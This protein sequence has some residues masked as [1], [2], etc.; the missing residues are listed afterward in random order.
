MKTSP[1]PETPQEASSSEA[2][3]SA[4]SLP[5]LSRRLMQLA[6]QLDALQAEMDKIAAQV[7]DGGVQV[8]ALVSHLTDAQS[9]HLLQTRLA[10]FTE[11]M[12]SE[13]EQLNFLEM[14]LADLATQEQIV[15]L[16]ATVA[17]QGQ[18]SALAETLKNLVRGIEK[19]NRLGETKEQQLGSVLGTLQEI[20]ARRQQAAE[21]DQERQHEQTDA[22]RR[23]AR[24]ELAADLLPALDGLEVAL[25]R[26]RTILARQRHDLAALGQLPVGPLPDQR[27]QPSPGLLD[28]LR[29][30]I[31][32]EGDAEGISAL[33]SAP[34]PESMAATVAAMEAWLNHLTLVRD[35]FSALL[36]Q[37]GI[38]PITTLHQKFDPRLHLAVDSEERGDVP[39]DTIVRELRK[40]YRQDQRVLRYAEV[41]VSRA[42]DAPRPA[43]SS[44]ERG[45]AQPGG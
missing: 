4:H 39:P 3:G 21:R 41:V 42:P 35:R 5:Q 33:S 7:E 28:K 10:E 14:K 9:T 38:R 11:Q 30:R 13:H 26:A 1:T 24:G 25:E 16:A 32:S 17:T 22:I 27:R 44:A 20:V 31:A 19:A 43:A 37:E 18:V 40:G 45:R 12:S 29:S 15:R 34:L 36:S 8:S 6:A 23:N 2:E